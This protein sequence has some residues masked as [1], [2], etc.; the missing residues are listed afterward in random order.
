MLE[1]ET[2]AEAIARIDMHDEETHNRIESPQYQTIPKKTF[3]IWPSVDS[4]TKREKTRNIL[5]NAAASRS[6]SD[7]VLRSFIDWTTSYSDLH[8]EDIGQI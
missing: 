1:D 3:R 4:E 8:L 6:T 7:D 5:T 2:I